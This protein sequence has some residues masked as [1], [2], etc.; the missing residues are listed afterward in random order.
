MPRPSDLETPEGRRKRKARYDAVLHAAM[1]LFAAH[2]EH[3]THVTDIADR[4]GVAEG[5]VYEYFSSKRE[6][7][8]YSTHACWKLLG[9]SFEH[10]RQNTAPASLSTAIALITQHHL[11]FVQKNARVALLVHSNHRHNQGRLRYAR[12]ITE[13]LEEFTTEDVALRA[14][15]YLTALLFDLCT[16]WLNVQTQGPGNTDVVQMEVA[17]SDIESCILNWI[18]NM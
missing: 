13:L 4:A 10:A 1:E 11:R 5:T 7:F 16:T 17:R 8:Q 12:A 18:E 2:G 9:D 3:A 15:R 14:Q 6:L